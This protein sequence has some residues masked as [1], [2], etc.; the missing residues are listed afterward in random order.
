MRELVRAVGDR[1]LL[2]GEAERREY[3]LMAAE[4]QARAAR[5]GSG[6]GEL[7]AEASAEHE[8]AAEAEREDAAVAAGTSAGRSPV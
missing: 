3:E 5:A 4:D 7:A 6:G 1:W 8:Q 2:L